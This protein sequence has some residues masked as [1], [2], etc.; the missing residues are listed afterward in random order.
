MPVEIPG[1][2]EGPPH[3]VPLRKIVEKC[4]F[5]RLMAVNFQ[6]KHTEARIVQPS[7]DDLKGGQF[8]GNEE[9]GFALGKSRS[10]EV[11]DGLRL[12][13]CGFRAK[14]KRIPG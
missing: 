11:C 8:L 13:G 6:A 5:L 12:A 1:I 10:N 9:H 14:A 4:S 2:F 3:I 7:A